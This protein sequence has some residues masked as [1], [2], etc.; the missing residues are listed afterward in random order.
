MIRNFIISALIVSSIWLAAIWFAIQQDVDTYL[1]EPNVLLPDGGQYFGEHQEGVFS[2]EGRI[3]WPGGGSYHG[4]FD[5]GLFSGFGRLQMLSGDYYEGEFVEGLL[6]G[7]GKLVTVNGDVFEGEFDNYEPDGDGTWTFKDDSSYVG[8]FKYGLYNGEGRYEGVSG[9]IYIGQFQDGYYHGQGKVSYKNGNSYTGQFKRGE[10]QGEGRYSTSDDRIYKGQFEKSTFS[11]LGTY[12]DKEYEEFYEGE[13]EDWIYQG[14]GKLTTSQGVYEGEFVDGSLEGKGTYSGHDGESYAGLF[15]SGSYHSKGEL[16]SANGDR[17]RGY[18][19]YGEY[20]GEGV[21]TYAQAQDDVAELKGKWSWGSF[22][23]QDDGATPIER[24]VETAL[25]NQNDLIQT[26]LDAILPSK[27]DEINL[28]FVG[29]GGDG[30]QD[31]FYKEVSMVQQTFDRNF[32]TYQRS[33]ILANNKKTVN[34]IALATTQS[35]QTTLHGM[36]EKMDAD[37]DILFLFLTSHGSKDHEFVLDQQGL[38]LP[39]LQAKQLGEMIDELPVKSKV[40]VI[41]AC[42]SGGF[43]PEL[44][45]EN[46]LVITAAAD[47]RR[48]FGCS[49]DADMTYFGRAF[50]QDAL[51]ESESF[52]AAFEKAKGLVTQREQEHVDG[53]LS[54]HS[55]PQISVADPIAQHL[56]LWREQLKEKTSTMAQAEWAE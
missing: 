28:F 53:I 7:Q 30:K 52:V 54:Q 29:V 56:K 8:E 9:E 39:G 25:Y 21:L 24:N 43:I 19:N 15:K 50:F 37:N 45:D 33:I 5:N 2:G 44:E 42:Y 32:D 46:T 6:S 12:S 14:Q 26:A 13:F 38:D 22:L 34:D 36:A 16:V 23:G 48:S 17:Y 31:V 35:L 40:I 1:L 10:Y 20:H 27:D 49:D 3:I 47:D 51:L 41:S 55:E 18:F 4:S 11:G